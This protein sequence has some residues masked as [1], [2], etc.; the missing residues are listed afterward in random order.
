MTPREF[1]GA[2]NRASCIYVY[3]AYGVGATDAEGAQLEGEGI[4]LPVPRTV[5]RQITSDA[6]E[7]Q[8][9]V[10]AYEQGNCLY[11]GCEP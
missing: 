8:S 9:D 5:A 1:A 11:I 4:F 6:K 2:I 7:C 10:E 3:V